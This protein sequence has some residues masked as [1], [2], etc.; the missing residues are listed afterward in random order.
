M[1]VMVR[2]RVHHAGRPPQPGRGAHEDALGTGRHEPVDEILREA[3]IDLAD[4]AGRALALV[5][6]G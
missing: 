5:A 6:A 2:D 4:T 3:Q 1:I